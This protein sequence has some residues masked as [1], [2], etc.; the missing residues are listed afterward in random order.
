[1]NR[2]EYYTGLHN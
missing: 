2:H 1:M